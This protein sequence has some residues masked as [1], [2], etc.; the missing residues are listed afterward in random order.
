MSGL[1]GD[2]RYSLIDYLR[3]IA[4]GLMIV[5]HFSYDLF[6]MR[7]IE[8]AIIRQSFFVVM[9][10][11]CAMLFLFCVGYSLAI[12]YRRYATV[13]EFYPR[14][15]K[16]WLKVTLAAVAVS[17][18]SYLIYPQWWIYFGILHC[19]SA[20]SLLSLVFLSVPKIALT[21][22]LLLMIVYWGWDVSLPW[23]KLPRGTLD[24][25]P[26]F[27]W[28]GMVLIGLG[29]EQ[30]AWHQRLKPPSVAWVEFLSRHALVIY[31][32]HQPM[33]LAGIWIYKK[34]ILTTIGA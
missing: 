32:M 5:Y 33:L 22:G 10:R 12:N 26:L 11:S 23:I 17:I 21:I 20:A 4:I 34:F 24:Y 13:N 29:A 15:F 28:A 25:F 14:F 27:P 18:G 1:Q 19:I 7:L 31:L 6:L 16:N 9:A 30:F 3:V 8:E 2:S